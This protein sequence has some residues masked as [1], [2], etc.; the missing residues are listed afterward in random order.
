[1]FKVP[2][3]SNAQKAWVGPLGIV[4]FVVMYMIPNHLHLFTP[5]AV[6][7]FGFENQIPFI[8]WT[9][10]VYMSDYLYIGLVFFLLKER[11]NMNRIYYSQLMMLF[12]FMLVFILF[13]TIYPRPVVEYS[14]F[15]GQSVQLLH[16]LDT[17]C[18][19]FP[20]LHVA[21]TFLAGYGFIKEQK[22]LL[23]FFM[24]WAILISVSTLTVKQH[25][26]LDVMG[27]FIMSLIFYKLG[28]YVRARR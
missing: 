17:P 10:W 15:A 12:F 9:V 5:A 25:Y 8:D 6:H 21:I 3:F 23:P 24:L 22:K 18:N 28:S 1:M 19:A 26:F 14:G 2:F 27:G 13:P 20:S 4:A 7:M 11:E 16:S